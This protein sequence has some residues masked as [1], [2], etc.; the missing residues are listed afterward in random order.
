MKDFLIAPSILSADFARLGED[1][2]KVL[3]AGADVVH[4]DVMDNHYVPNLTFGPMICKALRDY[5]IT[6]PIDVHLMVSPVDDLIEQ[7]ADAGASMISFHPEASQHVDRSLQLIIDKGCQPGLVFNPAT[8]LSHLDY[9]MDKLHHILLM[10]VNPGFGGQSF[11]PNTL[12][13]LREVKQRIEESGRNIRL[14]VDGGV[15]VDNIAAIADAGADMFV[16]GSAI[17]NQ[18]DY[19]TVIQQMRNELAS[20][21]AR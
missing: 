20:V 12:D 21:G 8:S 1:V 16:A 11:I 3:A 4:F 2:E 17:F 10:S 7:F 14:E 9:V 15:K 6:A 19:A 13:K 18:P 5:G